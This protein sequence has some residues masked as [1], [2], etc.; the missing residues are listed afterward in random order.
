M[1][2]TN[3]N[4]AVEFASRVIS[5]VLKESCTHDSSWNFPPLHQIF[6]EHAL[7]VD[8]F[9][10]YYMLITLCI[11]ECKNLPYSQL[12]CLQ[13]LVWISINTFQLE[14]V[15]FFISLFHFDE[16]SLFIFPSI[17]NRLLTRSWNL[18]FGEFFCRLK[19]S[20]QFAN[21]NLTT[22]VCTVTIECF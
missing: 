8:Y 15:A 2:S 11:N 9:Q 16:P 7:W 13:F 22:T 4:L 21:K 5:F 1:V 10:S 6:F 18:W 3:W 17:G 12:G 14:E 20:I 19:E